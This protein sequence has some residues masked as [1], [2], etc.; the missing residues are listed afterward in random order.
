MFNISPIVLLILDGWGFRENPDSNAI[1]QAN[2]PQWDQW[3]SNYPHMLL[4][5]SGECV[6]LPDQQMGNSEVGHMH[7]GAGRV[8]YQDLSRINL[9]IED[10]SFFD[11]PALVKTIETLKQN[12]GSFHIAGLLSPGGVHSHEQHLFA[13]I[14]LCHKM[15]FNRV[16]IHCFLDGRDTPPRSALESINKL[17]Q[18]LQKFPVGRIAT[19]SGR[20]YA[21]DR[22]KR[23]ERVLPVAKLIYSGQAL[24][25]ANTAIQSIETS[26]TNGVSDEFVPQPKLA[27]PA[28]LENG[29]AFFFFNFRADRARQLC[30]CL[31]DPIKFRSPTML[32]SLYPLL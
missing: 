11:N 1:A 12:G 18:L 26:Y 9:A 16:L 13:T 24:Y 30:Q 17:N 27:Q 32:V 6:G 5:A 29:D 8:V 3:W 22:D 19:I 28:P 15:Q 14:E 21:M 7:I 20:Y 25:H 4:T 2:T 31:L 10:G 23:W